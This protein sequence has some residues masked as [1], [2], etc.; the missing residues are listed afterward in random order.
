MAG[1]GGWTPELRVHETA[2][3]RCRLTLVG[4]TYGDGQSLQEAADDLVGRLTTIALVAR[5][6]GLRLPPELGPPDRRML[7]FVWELGEIALRDGDLRE[8]AL[9]FHGSSITPPG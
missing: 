4:L 7:E 5:A 8:R 6:R 2:A 3:G 9:G 1:A